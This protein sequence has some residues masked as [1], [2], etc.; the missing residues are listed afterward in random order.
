M[1][2]LMVPNKHASQSANLKGRKRELPRPNSKKKQKKPPYITVA[3]CTAM[4]SPAMPTTQPATLAAAP[5]FATDTTQPATSPT[6]INPMLRT[7]DGGSPYEPMTSV[8]AGQSTNGQ[9]EAR[10][11]RNGPG[12]VLCI[13]SAVLEACWRFARR[14][15]DLAVLEA[16]AVAC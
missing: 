3:F 15:V 4:P 13:A 8:A 16:R 6:A 5:E 7:I 10:P 11:Q 9:S 2:H 14:V 1:S 12:R